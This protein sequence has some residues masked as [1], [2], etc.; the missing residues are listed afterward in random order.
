ME[1]HFDEHQDRF[2]RAQLRG[3]YQPRRP[4]FY[5]RSIQSQFALLAFF[6][7][8]EHATQESEHSTRKFLAELLGI[9]KL[10]SVLFVLHEPSWNSK[11]GDSRFWHAR[12]VLGAFLAHLYEHAFAPMRHNVRVTTEFAKT[13]T[14]EHLYLYLRNEQ[15][16]KALFAHYGNQREFFKAL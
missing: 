3:E 5:A 4:L 7:E 10:V 6:T 2:Y 13:A 9:E 8:E 16:L 11:E 14:L 12:G 15:A 1:K